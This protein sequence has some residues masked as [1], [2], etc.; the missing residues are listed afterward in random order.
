MSL[1]SDLG[2]DVIYHKPVSDLVSRWKREVDIEQGFGKPFFMFW[3][4]GPEDRTSLVID[5][6]SKQLGIDRESAIVT[7]IGFS[8]GAEAYD[9]TVRSAVGSDFRTGILELK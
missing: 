9:K 5:Y 2:T 4:A 6:I 3:V 8:A 7:T 1:E